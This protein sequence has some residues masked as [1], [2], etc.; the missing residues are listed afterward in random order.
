[1]MVP[2]DTE[3][4]QAYTSVQG[5]QAIQLFGRRRQAAQVPQAEFSQDYGV[6]PFCRNHGYSA[7]D[8]DVYGREQ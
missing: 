6:L 8:A 4:I 7:R 3:D 5:V 1:M 2:H